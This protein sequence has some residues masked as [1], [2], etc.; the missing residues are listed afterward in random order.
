MR[1]LRY[2]GGGGGLDVEGHTALLLVLAGVGWLGS[3]GLYGEETL[4]QQES[5]IVAQ[6]VCMQLYRPFKHL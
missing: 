6:N 4:S 5:L 1:S 3:T 2:G